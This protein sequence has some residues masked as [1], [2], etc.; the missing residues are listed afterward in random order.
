MPKSEPRLND[1]IR[2]RLE[3]IAFWAHIVA[4]D[5][6]NAVRAVRERLGAPD[7]HGHPLGADRATAPIHDN[8]RVDRT[9]DAPT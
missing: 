1:R 3:E 4:T 8:P 7:P 2:A 6:A 5:D 9:D